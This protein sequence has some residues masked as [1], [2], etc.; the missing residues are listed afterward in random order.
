VQATC[1]G[2][3]AVA[4]AHWFGNARPRSGTLELPQGPTEAAAAEGSARRAGLRAA[5]MGGLDDR[6]AALRALADGAGAPEP[7]GI[8]PGAAAA[9]KRPAAEPTGLVDALHGA[10]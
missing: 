4:V 5:G 3:G 7:A 1:C 2:V 10:P 9:A 6:P 8:E